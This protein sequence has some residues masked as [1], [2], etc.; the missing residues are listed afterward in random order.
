ADAKPAAELRAIEAVVGR[1]LVHA[2]GEGRRVGGQRLQVREGNAVFEVQV[3][4]AGQQ[5]RANAEPPRRDVEGD[6]EGGLHAP[7]AAAAFRLGA[8]VDHARDAEGQRLL[9][10]RGCLEGEVGRQ[11]VRVERLGRR[12][13]L[14]YERAGDEGERLVGA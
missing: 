2:L 9:R 10:V 4:K 3:A 13:P 7:Q 6:G 11:A 1:E 14:Q 12:G 8:A 5:G